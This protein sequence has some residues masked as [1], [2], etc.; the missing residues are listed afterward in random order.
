MRSIDDVLSI[1]GMVWWKHS[2]RF[3]GKWIVGFAIDGHFDIKL[4]H[5]EVDHIFH[6][7]QRIKFWLKFYRIFTT[8]TK[9]NDAPAVTEDSLVHFGNNLPD[10]LVRHGEVKSV[11]ASLGQNVFKCLGHH[12]LELIHVYVEIFPGTLRHTG[13]LH[14]RLFYL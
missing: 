13:T 8:N 14:A 7:E 1:R 4:C 5:C 11:F 10:V 12:I 3:G 6:P 2:K 9:C